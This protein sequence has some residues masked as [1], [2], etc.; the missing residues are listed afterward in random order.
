MGSDVLCMVHAESYVLQQLWST[1]SASN[2]E[3]LERFKSKTLLMIVDSP[4]YVY[5]MVIRRDLQTNT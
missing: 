3:I 5:N 2:I 4:W 1:A